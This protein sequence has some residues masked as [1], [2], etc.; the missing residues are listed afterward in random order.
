[1]SLDRVRNWLAANAE[2]VDLCRLPEEAAGV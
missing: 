2:A 1:M